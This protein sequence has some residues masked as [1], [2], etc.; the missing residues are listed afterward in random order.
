MVLLSQK[1]YLWLWRYADRFSKWQSMI[2]VRELIIP[3][4]I[5]FRLGLLDDESMLQ[6]NF[7]TRNLFS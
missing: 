4:I 7:S 2:N 6:I 5:P 1:Q 3:K